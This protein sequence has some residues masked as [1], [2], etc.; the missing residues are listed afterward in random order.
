MVRFHTGAND[1]TKGK[2]GTVIRF[3]E[4]NNHLTSGPKKGF[5]LFS[6]RNDEDE[7]D[8]FIIH[9]KDGVIIKKS[10]SDAYVKSNPSEN[11]NCF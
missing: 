1:F 3:G 4:R 2:L 6:A 5:K 11:Q 10:L 7:V 9:K 8:L